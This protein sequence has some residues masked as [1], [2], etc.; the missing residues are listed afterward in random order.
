MQVGHVV[1]VRGAGSNEKVERGLAKEVTW[2]EIS[3]PT[4]F[5]F[6]VSPVIQCMDP[7]RDSRTYFTCKRLVSGLNSW[8]NYPIEM[9]KEDRKADAE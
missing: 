7:E 2:P 9:A 3:A 8:I 1:Q 6:D 4:R 5:C